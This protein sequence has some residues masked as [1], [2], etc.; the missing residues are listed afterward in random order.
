MSQVN[1]IRI[2]G[3]KIRLPKIEEVKA[4]LSQS[5]EGKILNATLTRTDPRN[6][7]FSSA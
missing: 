5:F 1:S 4:R 2:E 3:N 6:A 7:L